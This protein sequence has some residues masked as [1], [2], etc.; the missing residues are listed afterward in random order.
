MA[1]CA[2]R[3]G[4]ERQKDGWIMVLLYEEEGRGSV[5]VAWSG[6][7]SWRSNGR[8]RLRKGKRTRR[9]GGGSRKEEEDAKCGI[10]GGHLSAFPQAYT[11]LVGETNG[12]DPAGNPSAPTAGRRS[13]SAIL[14]DGSQPLFLGCR[15]YGGHIKSFESQPPWRGRGAPRELQRRDWPLWRGCW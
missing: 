7:S 15:S 3:L 5:R 4:D 13:G 10:W 2:L 1:R 12:R 6:G 9:G 8:D 11:K 14:Q